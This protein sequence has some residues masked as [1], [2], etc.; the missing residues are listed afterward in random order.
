M[1]FQIIHDEENKCYRVKNIKKDR[2]VKTKFK[3]RESAIR[4][5]QNWMR[6]RGEDPIVVGDLVTHDKH[7]NI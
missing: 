7:C 1:P 2:T 6:Y 3:T 4:Q 5:A